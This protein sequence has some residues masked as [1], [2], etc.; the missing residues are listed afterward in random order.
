MHR[1]TVSSCR[2]NNETP[3]QIMNP[4]LRCARRYSFENGRPTEARSQGS[5]I[6]LG[7]IATAAVGLYKVGNGLC[8]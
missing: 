1:M 3:G 5:P 8:R 6:A 2:N 4:S 7:M